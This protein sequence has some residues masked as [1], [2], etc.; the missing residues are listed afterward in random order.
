MAG[1]R[2]A[3]FKNLLSGIP[4]THT[5][6]KMKLT[7]L[8]VDIL[9]E[10]IYD[11]LSLQ[12]D[13]FNLMITNS[14]L[15][16]VGKPALYRI[17][18]ARH[19]S[20][21]ISWALNNEH[22]A[23]LQY[24]LENRS[25]DLEGLV[26]K[27]GNTPLTAA[28]EIGYLEGVAW[29]LSR[30]AN[31]NA[32]SDYEET[33]LSLA[34]REGHFDIVKLL[35]NQDGVE[36]DIPDGFQQTPLWWACSQGNPPILNHLLSRN[37]APGRINMDV[38]HARMDKVTPLHAAVSANH[39][40]I[41]QTLLTYPD[42]DPS[43]ADLD[44]KTPLMA[45][46][47]HSYTEAMD[48][49]LSHPKIDLD[50]RN[51]AGYKAVWMAARMYPSSLLE[52]LLDHG[53]NPNEVGETG[54]CILAA[55]AERSY[56]EN[57][58]L[59]LKY[60]A[61]PTIANNEGATPLHWAAL[62]GKTDA[63]ALLLSV[64][65][66]DAAARTETGWTPLHC[67]LEEPDSELIGFF[68]RREEVDVNA[69]EID[70]WTPLITAA[71][72]GRNAAVEMLLADSRVEVNRVDERGYSALMHAANKGYM[73]IVKALVG[74]ERVDLFLRDERGKMAVD[75]AREN[76]REEVVEFL[77]EWQRK[78]KEEAVVSVEVID[79]QR[80]LET[81]TEID[82]EAPLPSPS[83]TSLHPY[84]GVDA[85]VAPGGYCDF[86]AEKKQAGVDPSMLGMAEY[87]C[88]DP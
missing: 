64:S 86:F 62:C 60:G 51:N 21:A 22:L 40:S 65:S 84:R 30:G 76:R 71:Y 66:V 28:A 38:N 79:G 75:L 55:A 4:T 63:V 20:S 82:L 74:D 33:A 15:Y 1:A 73:G 70:E 87:G 83:A 26:G 54:F 29:L 32:Q 48:L 49:L 45:A 12:R 59:L 16:L 72:D 37:E 7:S 34:V 3:L 61:D 52:T 13:I 57:M 67:A 2:S 10:I 43:K 18:A 5:E 41:V 25:S 58:K 53:A 11:H 80:V 31:I 35:L 46:I 77:E 42:T 36:P 24:A 81:G 27:K 85:D 9:H 19:F 17:N 56:L 44:G 23:T 8:P 78:R 68:L 88:Q 47:V 6:E 69:V 39:I 14:K 50:A